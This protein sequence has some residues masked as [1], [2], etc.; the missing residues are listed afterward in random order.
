M[1]VVNQEVA[2]VTLAVLGIALG[3]V[4]NWFTRPAS[5]TTRG[6]FA[7][8]AVLLLAAAGLTWFNARS[9]RTASDPD[10]HAAPVTH[11]SNSSRP[12]WLQPTT[13]NT[14]A[15]AY[16]TAADI[17]SA[18]HVSGTQLFSLYHSGVG[19]TTPP[20]SY[21]FQYR[22][23][24]GLSIYVTQW[25]GADADTVWASS[26]R[27]TIYRPLPQAGRDASFEPGGADASVYWNHR[28]VAVWIS[29][30]Q[31]TAKAQPEHERVIKQL[32]ELAA[33]RLGAVK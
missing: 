18:Y 1:T 32:V 21:E 23:P 10:S 19:R 3:V 24:A 29:G 12:P 14:E 30:E 22:N 2:A 27:L 5:L 26:K 25:S 7:V 31:V 4:G 8:F 17:S 11:G 16:V 20:R 13:A 6:L 15:G 33:R 9:G 28:I